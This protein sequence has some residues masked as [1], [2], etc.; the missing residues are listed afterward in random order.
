[1]KAIFS[2]NPG[3][4]GSKYLADLLATAEETNAFHEARPFMS[5]EPLTLATNHPYHETFKQREHK[6]FAI[7]QNPKDKVYVETNNMFIKTFFDVVLHHFDCQIIALHRSLPKILKSFVELGYFYAPTSRAWNQ[8][9]IPPTAVTAALPQPL[10]HTL[11]HVDKC[12]AHLLDIRAREKRFI[13]DYPDT[14][15][16]TVSLKD[17]NDPTFV[18]EF[19]NQLN[20][21]P[22]EETINIIGKK[23]NGRQVLKDRINISISIE[24]ATQAIENYRRKYALSI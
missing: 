14:K 3:R 5:G 6:A 2:I 1:M 17:L 22:T 15:V 4:S 12:I 18:L 21:T 11:N 13:Q 24:E 19:F 7:K 8:W 20:I 9:L 16:Y 10:F 23:T